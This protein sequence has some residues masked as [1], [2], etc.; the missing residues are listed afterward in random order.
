MTLPD[1][2]LDLHWST[3]L[4]RLTDAQVDRY[5][6]QVRAE[7]EAHRHHRPPRRTTAQLNMERKLWQ[8][9]QRRRSAEGVR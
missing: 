8:E 1:S 3:N 2:Y 4:R 5:V 6:D 7:H 9:Q